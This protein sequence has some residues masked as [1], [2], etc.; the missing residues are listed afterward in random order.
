[1]IRMPRTLSLPDG[2]LNGLPP[3]A[4]Y[5]CLRVEEA[6]VIDGRLN[7][8]LWKRV[9]WSNP[10]VK[11]DT[12]E[13]VSLESR[14]ALLWDDDYLYAAFRY[15]DHEIWGT[16]VEH[17]DHVYHRDSDAEIFIDGND[18][19]YELG[20]NPINTIYEV[21]WTWLK[22]VVQRNDAGV[23]NR[24]FSAK[25]GLYFLPRR[26][27]F[28]GR[29]GE[30]DWQMPGL[31]H[32]VQINGSLNNPAIKDVGW[33]VEFALP[34]SGLKVLGNPRCPP[35]PGDVWRIGASRC[36]HFR[37][38]LDVQMPRATGD[39]ANP[40]HS[41]SE[42]WSWNQHGYVNMHMPERWTQVRFTDAVV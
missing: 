40:M 2:S 6:V 28:F 1:M 15:E 23:L 31:K 17:H 36:Q 38:K 35:T 18:A 39:R 3:I 20:V 21:L 9:Q 32:G 19:Y 42:D 34:W 26:D 24:L 10:F 22:P 30:T 13:A 11:M 37:L 14:I 8:A 29:F 25:N 41:A 7:E 4:I 27:E 12:G 5:E 16:H 33:T